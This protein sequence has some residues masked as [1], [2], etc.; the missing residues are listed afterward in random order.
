[1]GLLIFLLIY[2]GRRVNAARLGRLPESPAV[3]G[4]VCNSL[5]WMKKISPRRQGLRM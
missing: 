1:M 2:L 4:H 3:Q 5:C